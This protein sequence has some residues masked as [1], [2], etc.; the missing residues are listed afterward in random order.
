LVLSITMPKEEQKRKRQKEPIKGSKRGPKP[1]S[2][3]LKQTPKSSAGS[4]G[5]ITRKNL[6]LFDWMIVYAYVDTLPQP[7]KQGDV[8]KYFA[9]R[10]EGPLVFTQSTLS[11]KLQH[12][13]EMEARVTSNPNAL[14]RKRPRIVT[15]PDVDRALWLWVQ[16]MEHKREV[17]NSG[18]LI[19]KRAVFEEAL[20]VPEDERLTG[21]GWVQSFCQA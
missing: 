13:S 21:P 5:G 8:V 18:M 20:D 1:S 17:V 15:R 6:T 4:I 10:P 2:G 16:H 7:I 19:A 12:R 11:C 14:S 9:T 3:P